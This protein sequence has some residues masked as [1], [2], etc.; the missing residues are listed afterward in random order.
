MRPIEGLNIIYPNDK[1]DDKD[2]KINVKN[3]VGSDGL[4]S[5][6]TYEESG[7][8]IRRKN[9]KYKTEKYGRIFFHKN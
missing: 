9:F 3:M 7:S 4:R 2:A 6:I 5:M 1:L 8:P